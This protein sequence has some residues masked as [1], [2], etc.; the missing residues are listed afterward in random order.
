M[1]SLG[2]YGLQEIR[3]GQV[4]RPGPDSGPRSSRSGEVLPVALAVR[5]SGA[6]LEDM[7]VAV[8]VQTRHIV[9]PTGGPVPLT[10]PPRRV[11]VVGFEPTTSAV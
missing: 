8:V 3:D 5:D 11:G 6:W 4:E 7:E 2:L 9:D 10:T 1:R